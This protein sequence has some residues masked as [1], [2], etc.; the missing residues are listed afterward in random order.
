MSKKGKTENLSG[1][2]QNQKAGNFECKN[3]KTDLKSD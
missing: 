1:S 3:R 2:D